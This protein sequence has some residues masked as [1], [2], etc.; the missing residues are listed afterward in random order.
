[1]PSS[2]NRIREPSTTSSTSNDSPLS[3]TAL[4][5]SWMKS[6]N[7]SA[8]AS[9]VKRTVTSVPNVV[10]PGSRAPERSTVTR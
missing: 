7:V 1:M 10:A 3:S 4:T 9:A 2:G 6:M 8:P 5:V